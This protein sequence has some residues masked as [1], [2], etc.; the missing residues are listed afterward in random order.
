[1]R[2]AE[3]LR[4]KGSDVTTVRSDASV[5]EAIGVLVDGRFGALPVSDDGKS[6]DGII[7]ER[8]VVRALTEGDPAG[9]GE[10][11]VSELMTAQV[12]T[13]SPDASLSD[14]MNLMNERRIRHVPVV[15]RGTLVGI[16][17]MR[18]LVNARLREAEIERQQMAEYIANRTFN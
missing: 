1:M 2:I 13:C 12:H 15:D 5:G 6:L 9:L 7:S 4:E 3:I 10:R 17:S 14:A 11:R 16:L 8:D 18:D